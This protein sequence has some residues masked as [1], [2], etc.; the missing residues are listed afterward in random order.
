MLVLREKVYMVHKLGLR[1]FD[2]IQANATRFIA[3]ER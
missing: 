1:R 2:V 3:V